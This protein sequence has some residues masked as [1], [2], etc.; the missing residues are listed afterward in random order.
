[1]FKFHYFP[2]LKKQI[3]LETYSRRIDR[4]K[5]KIHKAKLFLDK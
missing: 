2:S 1:M 3:T 5:H 4:R